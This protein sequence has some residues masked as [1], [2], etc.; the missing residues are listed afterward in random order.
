MIPHAHL[1]ASANPSYDEDLRAALCGEGPLWAERLMA[2]LASAPGLLGETAI[3]RPEREGWSLVAERIVEA[4]RTHPHRD[5]IRLAAFARGAAERIFPPAARSAGAGRLARWLGHSAGYAPDALEPAVALARY[6]DLPSL[7]FVSSLNPPPEKLLREASLEVDTRDL[8]ALAAIFGRASAPARFED[9]CRRAGC[10]G[11]PVEPPPLPEGTP[12]RL[13]RI[14]LAA[15]LAGACE[16]E[17]EVAALM[18]SV[19]SERGGCL[20][21]T[22]GIPGSGKTTWLDRHLGAELI[23]SMDRMR[24]IALGD[25]SD[26]TQ[27]ELIYRQ[28]L[29]ALARA[30]ERG[31]RVVFDATSYDRERRESLRSLAQRAGAHLIMLYFDV[32]LD[33]AF[34]RNAR[35]ARKVPSEVVRR[36]YRQLEPPR[37]DEADAVLLI[38]PSWDRPRHWVF[39]RKRWVWEATP[40]DHVR[41]V[42]G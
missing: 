17:E 23:V 25:A 5:R 13:R 19:P 35:R 10:W 41:S 8:A 3:E 11:K 1:R 14:A 21:A 39:G 20:I 4:A 28:S 27:N 16:T 26:Q 33:E 7:E 42:I 22:V 15:M 36:A 38:S 24:S 2:A 6:A 30:L 18:R 31:K 40:V 29:T 12:A 37:P 32:S 9:A 34:R